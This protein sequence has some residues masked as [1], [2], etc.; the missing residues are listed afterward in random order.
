LRSF[1]ALKSASEAS[2][3]KSQNHQSLNGENL[4]M[5]SSCAEC[6]EAEYA[7]EQYSESP[8]PVGTKI[9]KGGPAPR[10]R[11]RD[12]ALRIQVELDS[13]SDEAPT[14]SRSIFLRGI[15][16]QIDHNEMLQRRLARSFVMRSALPWAKETLLRLRQLCP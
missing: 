5:S 9:D 16:L 2:A 1:S 7:T 14:A 8:P 3:L 12:F 11:S 15:H 13:S 6:T 4:F 10:K